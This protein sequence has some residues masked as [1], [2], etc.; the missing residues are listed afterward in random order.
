MQLLRIYH[1]NRVML[2]HGLDELIPAK[3]LPWYV[4]LMR[5][6]IFWIRNQHKDKNAG[7]RLTLALQALGPVFIKFGQ[8]LSTRRD[9]LPPEI[10]NELAMLQDRV[11]PFDSE[12]AT[13]IILKALNISSLDQVFSEFSESPLASA[14]IAQVHAAKLK[15]CNTDVVVKVLRPD[16]RKTIKAD[17]EL[18]LTF[19]KVLQKWLPDGKRLRPVEVVK[20]YEKTIVDEL[21]LNREAANG[22]QLGRNFEGSEALYVPSIYSDYCTKNVLVMERIYGIPISNIEAL[23]EQ[24]TNLRILAERGVEVFFTQVFRDSF[25]H[26]DMHPGNIF[27]SRENPQNPQYIA[28]DF[29]IVGTLNQEDK[30]Y[31]AENF[32]AF[33]N[34][35]YRKVAQL[36]ADSGWVPSDTNIDEFEVAIRT[37]C[38]PIFQKPLAEISFGNVLVQ[39]FNTARRFNMVVQPQLVLLQKT[40]LY[41]EGLGRQLYPQLDLWQTAKP[42]LENWMREQIGVRAMFSK[43]KS[44]LPYWSEKLPDMPDLLYDTLKQVKHFPEKQQQANA[45]LLQQQKRAQKAL[46]F[47][48]VGATLIIV[49]AILPLYPAHWSLSAGLALLGSSC[50]FVAWWKGRR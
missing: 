15:D 6:S 13:A 2:E 46:H 17:T 34:R 18:M 41:I 5:M 1:I 30:R 27:V 23:I 25:F 16:I 20:E 32:I 39:L 38:E 37:V 35:D 33:F 10:A 47:S 14:S 4:R 9:L 7:A 11:K 43:V 31:L 48:I 45:A 40:L 3:W 26:A 19:A 42:F 12:R 44:N 36:H 28:I 21:D 50:W 29:G 24:D 22:M 49:A 8:M